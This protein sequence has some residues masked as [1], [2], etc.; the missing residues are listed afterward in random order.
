V[1]VKPGSEQI[2]NCHSATKLN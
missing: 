1:T 2:Q